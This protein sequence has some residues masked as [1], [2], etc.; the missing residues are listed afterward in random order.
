MKKLSMIVACLCIAFSAS[1]FYR[2]MP[3]WTL[4]PNQIKFTS[5]TAAPTAVAIPGAVSASNAENG[6][7]DEN[8]NLLFFVTGQTVYNASGTS[9]GNL[10]T[11][12][13]TTGTSP[14]YTTNNYNA[15]EGNE[16]AIV[17]VPGA[18]RTYYIIYAVDN[19]TL[20]TIIN[21]LMYTTVTCSG[22][23]VTV[24][25]TGN[26]TSN[27]AGAGGTVV[28]VQPQVLKHRIVGTDFQATAIAVSRVDNGGTNGTATRSLYWVTYSDIY[29]FT[30]SASGIVPASTP[31]VGT[32]TAGHENA[33]I[34]EADLDYT[35]TTST[36][37]AWTNGAHELCVL[38]LGV[39]T[40]PSYYPLPVPIAN[41]ISST[42]NG[43]EFDMYG[44]IYISQSTFYHP[45]PSTGAVLG[46]IYKW[47][48]ST[49][50]FSTTAL[51][52]STDYGN[53]QLEASYDGN[54]DASPTYI[55]N[56][57]GVSTTGKLGVI[58]AAVGTF[59]ASP[60]SSVTVSSTTYYHNVNTL[61]D[62][63]DGEFYSYFNGL[64]MPFADFYINGTS[65]P[66]AT[67][68]S[69]V[70][71]YTCNPIALTNNS[72]NALSYSITVNSVNTS[73]TVISGGGY[74]SYSSGTIT[75]LP[76]D[77]R[78]MPG[79]NGTWLS[80]HPGLY[81]VSITASNNCSSPATQTAIINVVSAV[82]PSATLVLNSVNS[83]GQTTTSTPGTLFSTCLNA[84][85]SF[86]VSNPTGTITSWQKKVE[87]SS[88]GTGGPWT[89]V[90]SGTPSTG[91]LASV[92]Q[93]LCGT[94][95]NDGS[96]YRFT[97]EITNPCTS[98]PVVLS[99]LF[100]P[101]SACKTDETTGIGDKEVGDFV[102]AYP[103]PL[104]KGSALHITLS[105]SARTSA[106]LT[107]MQ[108]RVV[109]TIAESI[110]LPE[111]ESILAIGAQLPAGIYLY[112]ITAGSKTFT[113]RVVKA[114]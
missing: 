50:T 76:S 33:T 107:D 111:G 91:S 77:L 49:Q 31:I 78:A 99:Q 23:S 73:C 83:S 87:K 8:N 6:V 37:L 47:T 43:Q 34:P 51:S 56:I 20:P 67:C 11:A 57:Y 59:S 110:Q 46:G 42:M 10:P 2:Q 62:Q 40:T 21:A 41:T 15:L 105:R 72:N 27:P 90:Y 5:G 97:I 80:N 60:L 69:P 18:C 113:G 101:N 96:V 36:K 106:Y 61:P 12:T 70:Q 24:S 32:M 109:Q 19:Y 4:L 64:G 17:P 93:A 22:G 81:K 3:N 89:T 29:K 85:V 68:S 45:T 100:Q 98:T 103:V 26:L 14:F 16:I 54:L 112:K 55:N 7:Y 74:L 65:M 95:I 58:N 1:A 63:I 104:E 82:S 53:T 44:N 108:G 38:N 92:N 28:P 71:A 30:I 9:V 94:C 79:T 86:T 35:G 88:G 39:S 48:A 84:G 52:G 75:T 114:D 13:I 66:N 102:S 25:P